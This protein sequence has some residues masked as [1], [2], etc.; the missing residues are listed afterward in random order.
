[1][2][3]PAQ[4]SLEQIFEARIDH[5]ATTLKPGSLHAYRLAVKSFLHYLRTNYPEVDELAALR[6]DP[7]ILGW[8]R[9]LCEQDPPLSKGTRFLYLVCFR[10]LL[11][12][13]GLSGD[14]S[15]LEGLIVRDD[16]PPLDHYLPKPLSPEDDRLLQQHLRGNDDLR[17]NALLLLRATG[18][19][20]GE[21]L[22]LP[23]D[24]LRDLGE[25][26]WALHVPL[27]KL[28]TERLVPI[29]DD[30]RR[31]HTRLL[32]LRQYSAAAARSSFLLPQLTGHQAAYYALRKAL[33][34][35]ARQAGCSVRPR[36][37]QLRHS[38]ATEMLRLGVSLTA[39]KELLG[40]KDIRM[41]MRYI[42][43]VQEDLQRQYRL[44]RQNMAGL[45][46]IPQLTIA[47][48]TADLTPGIPAITKSLATIRHLVEMYR[49]QLSH[50]QARRKLQRLGKRLARIANEVDRLGNPQE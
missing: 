3:M 14:Y 5:L 12:D 25:D 34:K 6:R 37:H 44:A 20:I 9:H 19:R 36:P 10:R 50:E 27:G 33:V 46:A 1:M 26:K 32:L 43:I 16:F 45:H 8:L 15:I 13:L 21:L 39:V 29:D 49:R 38:Y 42:M 2:S 48:S 47:D 11:S 30:I 41:T 31:I 23:T 24:C 28:H 4:P 7:H 40:H 18:M 17:S 22:H 35:A